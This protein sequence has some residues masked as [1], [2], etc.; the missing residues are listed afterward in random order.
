MKQNSEPCSELR[1]W[2]S[3]PVPE[4]HTVVVACDG[5]PPW[6]SVVVLRDG[7]GLHGYWNV[8][9]HL[10]IP[11]DSGAGTLPQSDEV[12]A[13][14]ACATHGARFRVADGVCVEGPCAGASLYPIRV[15]E[16]DARIWYEAEP[17][18]GG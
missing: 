2:L 5:P 14:I 4:G 9:R 6:R 12:P 18:A 8:C 7:D 1:R 10:P 11:L 16:V 15:G 13:T 3:A 17:P